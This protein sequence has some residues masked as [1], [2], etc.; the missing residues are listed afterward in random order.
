M[1]TKGT[2]HQDNDLLAEIIPF[3]A[4]HDLPEPNRDV[5][6]RDMLSDETEAMALLR[7]GLI[8]LERSLQA[9]AACT[10]TLHDGLARIEARIAGMVHN[11]AAIV[12]TGPD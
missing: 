1:P 6:R 10:A 12:Q 11:R 7:D 5:D 9:L 3:R 2:M 4:P 8:D